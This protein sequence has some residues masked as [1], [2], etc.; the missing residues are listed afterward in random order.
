[1]AA[2]AEYMRSAIRGGD[3]ETAGR[4]LS[5]LEKSLRRERAIPE[6]ANAIAL[7]RGNRVGNRNSCRMKRKLRENYGQNDA[8][9]G[10]SKT[11]AR[12]AQLLRECIGKQ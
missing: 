12:N 5:F 3:I 4:V 8:A 10:I 1:M 7:S 6:I 9:E 11:D 2:L